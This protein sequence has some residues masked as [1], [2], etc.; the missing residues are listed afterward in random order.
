M[1]QLVEESSSEYIHH[2]S[3]ADTILIERQCPSASKL[4]LDTTEL[5]GSC[6]SDATVIYDWVQYQS[7]SSSLSVEQDAAT[8]LDQITDDELRE[9]LTEFGYNVGP[10][11]ETTRH[12]YIQKL[13]RLRKD[14]EAQRQ[15]SAGA[16]EEQGEHGKYR[17]SLNDC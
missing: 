2:D 10:I 9:Q 5:E 11:T 4:R 8:P 17:V 7:L 15:L 6:A 14:P 1:T 13:N 3:E 12:V 16:K